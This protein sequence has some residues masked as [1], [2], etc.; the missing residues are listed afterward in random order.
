MSDTVVTSQVVPLQPLALRHQIG[1]VIKD[2]YTVREVLGAGAFGTVY[3]VEE[4][5]GA[6]TVTLACKEMHVLNDPQTN[7]DER[8]DALRM[9]QEEAYLL[10]TLRN[11]HIPAAYFES[12]KGVWL[13]CPVCGQ[14]FRGARVCPEHGA[15]LQLVKERY[16]LIMDFIEGPDLEQKLLANGGRPLAESETIDW[17]LQVCDALAAV[18]AKGFS[19]RDIKPANIKIQNESAQA[20]LIDFG[21]VKPS[22]VV[23]GYGTVLKRS[24]TGVGTIGYAPPSPQE[25]GQPDARTDILALGMTLYRLLTGRDP[26]EPQDLDA[27][28]RL[29]PRSFNPLVSAPLEGIIVR[30]IQV[31]PAQRY[32]DVSALRTD[33]RAARYPVET[34]C[35][36][37][38]WV[39]RTLHAPD[40]HTLC[41]QCGRPLA[42]GHPV[43]AAAA[44]TARKPQPARQPAAA[45]PPPQSNPFEPRIHQIQEELKNPHQAGNGQLDAR[46]TAITDRLAPLYNFAV[47]PPDLCPA[48]QKI[49]LVSVAGQPTGMCPLCQKAQ[50][51][52]RQ[53]ELHHCPVCRQ[54][55]LR[56]EKLPD[57]LIICPICR[58]GPVAEER[59]SRFAGMVMDLWWCCPRCKAQ[60]D[61]QR[62]G[63]IMLVNYEDDPY[64]VGAQQKGQA[65]TRDEWQRLST[66]SDRCAQCPHCAATLDVPDDD[67]MTLL[68]AP[69]DPY[70]VGQ[71]YKGSTLM[72]S[73][74]A[75]LARDLPLSS[76]THHC[77]QCLAE[78]DYDRTLHT[79]TL[80]DGA[81]IPAWAQRWRGMPVSLQSWYFAADGKRSGNPGLVCPNCS[82]EFDSD[83]ALLKL[84]ST[85]AKALGDSLNQSLALDDWQRRARNMPT[86]EEVQQLRNELAQLQA[87]KNAE[88]VQLRRDEQRRLGKL[89]EELMQLYKQSAVGGYVPLKRMSP[90]A[91]PDDWKHMPGLFVVLPLN[92]VH[93]ALRTSEVLRWESAAN[94]CSVHTTQGNY[95]W[96]RDAAGVLLVTTERVLFVAQGDKGRNQLWQCGLYEMSN[97]E[98]QTVQGS[99][100]VVLYFHNQRPMGFEMG[101]NQWS[102]IVDG[103]THSLTMTP[104][105]LVSMLR[106][107]ITSTA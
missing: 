51:L 17:A 83:G 1:D 81:N 21:L 22:T 82:T 15:P 57:N 38:G 101:V 84:V 66:R 67:R 78:Y 30:A 35:P 32:P 74:W 94:K 41:E 28:R 7:A 99:T 44:P 26:T 60:F 86:G 4:T 48:C 12:A 54:D 98:I 11:T 31:N 3:R 87:K 71:R 106:S 34:A 23:G 68:D 42:K 96:F 19:H 25:Q 77:P 49:K 29:T 56:E 37:C 107:L 65:H 45:P 6:R 58:G 105:D 91:S 63:K 33:L 97:V 27:M 36:N 52:R 100:V 69:V 59:R 39:Q 88:Q 53:W 47:N 79:M 62:G 10:Q 61:T 103:A 43:V 90:A 46:I 80:L 76:G 89:E 75:R 14:V 13:A 64:G 5:L 95:L 73:A 55:G 92:V 85:T 18:H 9:F 40:A 20:M 8:D 93:T 72:R 70:G 16:Y 104:D 102:L 24:S 2:R 50:L